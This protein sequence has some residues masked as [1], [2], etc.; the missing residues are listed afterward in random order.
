MCSCVGCEKTG[1]GID[2]ER[3][4]RLVFRGVIF[5]SESEGEQLIEATG[6]REN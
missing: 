5:S 2:T 4:L 1:D 3:E 6:A